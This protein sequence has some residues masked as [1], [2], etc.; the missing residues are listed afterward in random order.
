MT[1]AT[2]FIGGHVA[3]RLLDRGDEVVALVRTPSK[4]PALRDIGCELAEADLSDRAALR[5]AM[6]GCDAVFHIAAMYK[7]G[8]P[9]SERPALVEANVRGTER[10]IDG[11]VEAGV[12]RIVYVSTV[13]VLGNTKGRVLDESDVRPRTEFLSLYDETKYLAHQVAL[14]RIARGAPVVIAMPGGVYGPGD[15]SELANAIDQVRTGR[16]KFLVF[17]ETGFVF[18]HVEDAA[19]GIIRVHDRG[20]IG[21]SYVIGGEVSTLGDLVRNVAVLSG[22]KPPRITLPAVLSRMAI[23]LAPVVTRLMRM[24]PNLRELIRAADGV[25]YWGSDAKARRELGYAPRDLQTGLRQTLAAT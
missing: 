13:N 17:P 14:D 12:P 19:D 21:E 10:V 15:T 24:P 23:P 5:G 2:G 4:A 18:L 16:L 8:V 6:Q 3:R 11:A 20:R 7:V 9:A 22:R 25:T 1:G